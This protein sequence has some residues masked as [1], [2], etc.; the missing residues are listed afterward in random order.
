MTEGAAVLTADG[1]MVD[2]GDGQI[3]AVPKEPEGTRA[4]RTWARQ[5]VT[6]AGG[7]GRESLTLWCADGWAVFCTLTDPASVGDWQPRTGDYLIG[8]RRGRLIIR[9]TRAWGVEPEA[10]PV[11][12]VEQATAIMEWRRRLHGELHRLGGTADGTGSSAIVRTW[13]DS[14]APGGVWTRAKWATVEELD[15]LRAALYGGRV[16]SC[17]RHDQAEGTPR[18]GQ[19]PQTFRVTFPRGAR[20]SVHAW[21][22]GLIHEHGRDVRLKSARGAPRTELP[23]GW[24]MH[25]YDMRRAYQWAQA[26][27]GMPATWM[28][29][30]KDTSRAAL[31]RA[32]VLD[33]TVTHCGARA[34]RLP[35]HIHASGGDTHR[36]PDATRLPCRTVWPEGDF[37]ARGVWTTETLR[38]VER[39][40]G[41]VDAIHEA[42]TW[43]R[44]Y[45]PWGPLLRALEARQVA[46]EC[47]RVREA[48]K[49]LGRRAFG[50]MGASRKGSEWMD[51]GGTPLGEEWHPM[52]CRGTW[53][54]VRMERDEYAIHAQPVWA[55]L[56][57][58]RVAIRLARTCDA[59][60]ESG[61]RVLYVD[62]DSALVAVPPDWSPPD[63]LA[64]DGASG[65]WRRDWAGA[66]ALLCSAR[67]YALEGGRCAF[68]GV[69]RGIHQRLATQGRAR[70]TIAGRMVAFELPRWTAD[71]YNDAREARE[72]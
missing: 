44:V 9:D 72:F 38:E 23:P 45:D 70:A 55:A 26:L 68:A 67:W 54:R 51:G 14:W 12:P 60:H 50:A 32:G 24:T 17:Y 47:P 66:W 1:V 2:F 69:P 15:T 52:A 7:G 46:A 30:D 19:A 41:R 57:A 8:A 18:A 64:D 20:A 59:L 49:G 3:V 62:T 39:A 13:A 71:N 36:V 11:E 29:P 22:E 40:G 56:T 31:A 6:Q 61:A 53:S 34:P 10:W 43:A 4:R 65:S 33:A 27:G 21:Y 25:R 42:W 28:K 5:L 37:T 35:L 58:A 16:G 48:L 63:R